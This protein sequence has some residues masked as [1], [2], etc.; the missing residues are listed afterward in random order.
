MYPLDVARFVCVIVFLKH[1]QNKT[2][3][4]HNLCMKTCRYITKYYKDMQR[5]REKVKIVFLL[6]VHIGY[7]YFP[8]LF[9][10]K[11]V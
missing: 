4:M 9:A 5:G 11:I 6:L 10:K 3:E 7:C 8:S 1:I 2:G